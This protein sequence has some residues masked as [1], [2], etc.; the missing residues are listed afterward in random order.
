MRYTTG[1]KLICT[2][3]NPNWIK[4]IDVTR[5]TYWERIKLIFQGNRVLGPTHN[6][7]VTFVHNP[8]ATPG[9]IAL[10][11]YQKFGNYDERHFEPLVAEGVLEAELEEI[12]D[13]V[14]KN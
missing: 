10:R 6:E 13:K 11:E 8:Q 4:T 3:K 14:S 7:I 12:F 9:F 2:T 5:L 1:Q